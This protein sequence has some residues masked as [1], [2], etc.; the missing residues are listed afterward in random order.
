MPV[1]PEGTSS[2][3][4]RHDEPAMGRDERERRHTALLRLLHTIS[5]AAEQDADRQEAIAIVLTDMCRY[6]GWPLGH[7]YLY[8]ASTGRLNPTMVWHERETG[9]HAPF[10][11]A[12]AATELRTGE[13]L[14]GRALAERKPQWVSDLREDAGCVRTEAARAVGLRSAVAVPVF[15]NGSVGAVLEFFSP[16]AQPADP[17][18]LAALD[19]VGVAWGRVLGV[20]HLEEQ[21]DYSEER[22]RALVDSAADAIIVAGDDGRIISWNPSA[23]RMFG[24]QADEVVGGPLTRLMPEGYRDRHDLAFARATRREPR[25]SSGRVLEVEGLRKDGRTF[26]VEL[27]LVS[28][29]AERRFFAAILRDVTERRAAQ[30]E[31]RLLG[32]AAAHVRDAIV[33]STAGDSGRGP[34]ILYVNAAFT[35][36]TGYLEAEALGRSFGLLAGPKTDREAL[37]SVHQRLRRG[38]AASTEL[39]AYRKDGSEFLLEWH[40][41]P[42]YEADGTIRHFASIQR[43][44]TEERKVE[45]ALRRAD[46]DPLTGL[47]NRQILEKRLR[48][49]MERATREHQFALLFVD[50]DGFKEVNDEHGHVIGDQLLAAT[51]RR[52][53][54]TVRPGDTLARFGGD[55]FVILLEYVSDI[56]D[57]IMVAD[58]VQARLATPFEVQGQELSV[59]ASIGIALSESGYEAPE[60]MIRDADD[61]MYQA[62]RKGKGRAEF[63]DRSLYGDVVSLLG[64]QEDLRRA[65]ERGELELRY[66]PLVDLETGAIIGV[67]ALV[68]WQH[69]EHGLVPP[70]QFIPMAE[71]SGSIVPIGRWVL[72]EACAAAGRWPAR[73]PS[74]VPLM[75]SVNLSVRELSSPD[76][77]DSIRSILEETGLDPGRLQLEMTE[78]VFVDTLEPV[79][80]RLEEL[81]KLGI[82]VCIDDF[83]T[84]YSSLGYLHRFPIDKL[85][86]DRLFI[87]HLEEAPGNLEILRTILTLARNLRM[88]VVAEGVETHAQLTCLKDM[89]CRYA[90]GFLFSRPIRADE[91]ER[92]LVQAGGPEAMRAVESG[93]GGG[94]RLTG[95]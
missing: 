41:S 29:Q 80:S 32:S 24:Y 26:P 27:S 75:L 65:L 39:I 85:K 21:L 79:R 31:V 20:A 13:G 70:D 87:H 64:L 74:G 55:E 72:R 18:L 48:R 68:R 43:D 45:Q 88:D 22:F 49:A 78:S 92:L 47:P 86:I 91:V 61:A 66:Q 93:D 2:T 81:R 15:V 83:G 77:V 82:T 16:D 19:Y 12:T 23:A 8:D 89:A 69:A 50:L 44:V 14:P 62:K 56:S 33:V 90:Q 63:H 71:E 7:A 37:R 73:G 17:E 6:L 54:R 34:S 58:R 51:A 35:R 10:L 59:A 28:W 5:V 38:E 52:L 3:V 4:G 76:L 84:G 95:A 60:D 57:V 36:M 46:R 11:E 42:I 53:E 25:A 30:E 94:D 67:E 40:A 9:A 1:N